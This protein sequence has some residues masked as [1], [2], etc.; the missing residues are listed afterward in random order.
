MSSNKNKDDIPEGM[1]DTINELKKL[2][3][4][5][6]KF[7]EQF[8]D[9]EDIGANFSHIEK[10]INELKDNMPITTEEKI[11]TTPP[12]IDGETC[13]HGNSWHANCSDCDEL[14]NVEIAL[15]EME[16]IIKNEPNDKEL[17]KKIR[18]FYNKW[19]EIEDDT[20]I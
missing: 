15:N 11:D 6:D 16:N 10:S 13:M 5:I 2:T 20:T 19:K 14:D 3:S 9:I 1:E 17:G 18:D 4:E 8:E 12:P 7:A